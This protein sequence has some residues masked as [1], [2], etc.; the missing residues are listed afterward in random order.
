TLGTRQ[1]SFTVADENGNPMSQGT[2]I[3]VT[4][5]G[6]DTTG[7]V[8]S[9]D[10]EKTLPD[11]Y[12]RSFTQ[13]TVSVA[14]KRTKNL[15]SNIPI[16]ITVEV[17]GENGNVKKTFSGL[18]SSA[19]S[20]NGA[21]GSIA[22]VNPNPDSIRVAGAGTPNSIQV[23]AQVLTANG[24]PSPNIPVNFAI[25]RSVDG[26]EYLSNTLSVTDAGG[27]ATT[28]LNSGVKA[29]LVQVQAVVKRDSL[30]VAS[31]PKNVYIR[32]GQLASIAVLGV[33][34]T[35]LSVRGG[36]GTEN[37]ILVFEGRDSLGNAIDVS[38]QAVFTFSIVG[39]TAG[40]RIS[41]A[42]AKTD[43]NTG[44]V[45]ASLSS[46]TQSG[47]IQIRALSGSVQ[48]PPATITV[49]GGFAVDSL[50]NFTGLKKNYSIYQDVPVPITVL[51]GDRY[52]NPVKP[53]TPVAF[54]SD[55]GVITAAASTDASGKAAA[56]L[57]IVNDKKLLGTRFVSAKTIGVSGVEVKKSKTFILTGSPIITVAG[58]PNDSI[59]LFDGTSTTLNFVI[60]DSLGNPIA[61]GHDLDV[62][63]DGSV[64]S[65]I[66]TSGDV[67]YPFGDTDD[68]VGGTRFSV[69][70]GDLLPNGG[71]GGTFKVRITVNGVTG[72]TTKTLQ[73]RLLAPANI[74]V[75]PTARVPAS[76]A[77]ISTSATDISIAGVGGIE[78]ATLT[79]EVR[80]S[81]GAPITIDNQATVQ[82]KANFFPNRY[83]PGGTSPTILPR[84]DSTDENGRVRV[85]IMS[86]TQA[87]AVQVEAL[88]LLDNP[89]R[90]IKSQPVR[91]SVNSGFPDQNHFTIS[92]S[93]Y[94]FPSF[95][96]AINGNL[97]V[98]ILAGDKF[99]NPVKEGTI[100]YFNSAN[101]V[102]QTREG[103]T[104]KDGLVTMHLLSGVP[105][106]I[107]PNLAHG[108]TN[109]FSRIY[110]TTI[111]RD[112]NLVTDSV[113]ILWSGAPEYTKTGG[114]NTFTIAQGGSAG[115][116]TFSVADFLSHPMSEGTSITVDGKGLDISGDA[117]ILMPDTKS[118]GPG[119]T[120]FTVS[121]SDI[122]PTDTNPPVYSQLTLTVTHPV[123]GTRKWI[124]ATGTVD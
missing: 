98:T 71:T 87:G 103:V 70:V 5:V 23:Q 19:I 63:V 40:V 73:G 9:G 13:Y 46:G 93:R 99:S 122:D 54:T 24:Q 47:I 34:Q 114:P 97:A 2:S 32:T 44:R 79:Y 16:S 50:F 57:Q 38:N 48:S 89:I 66:L 49:A 91:I 53:A 11:T 62:T 74:D 33:S 60:A 113:D 88:I 17:T 84:V 59:T 68:R 25:V 61:P 58:V 56:S 75:P 94:N 29:G 96:N 8:L 104:N 35:S 69:I 92:P 78:N 45:T 28:T 77:L 109:G 36:G 95:G 20:S 90:T 116:F 31:E 106:P 111:D 112:S 6:F 115:P 27:I 4:G 82:F 110:A 72:T 43:P 55:A 85:V 124:L 12:D 101:G 80:D 65:Q 121:V 42:S 120:T 22:L 39:D 10:I 52:G 81:V 108:L 37:S 118:S 83:V 105:Y 14:D 86:G 67:T 76:I 3:K 15:S 26:G 119:L 107:A 51:I 7:A 21:V 64:A 102:I 18:L 1:I 117:N 123:F 41:P 100:V 30:A